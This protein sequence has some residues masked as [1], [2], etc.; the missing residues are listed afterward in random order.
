[1]RLSTLKLSLNFE[2]LVSNSGYAPQQFG[3][4]KGNAWILVNFIGK[5]DCLFNSDL[6]VSLVMEIYFQRQPFKGLLIKGCSGNIQQ[7][8]RRTPMP[9]NDFNKVTLQLYWNH[10][11]GWEFSCKFVAYSQNNFFL[12]YPWRAASVFYCQHVAC[13]KILKHLNFS[14]RTIEEGMNANNKP[15]I[16]HYLRAGLANILLF[17]HVLV[18]F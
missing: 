8:Y 2:V 6:R 17:F 9:K 11:S 13:Y 18:F 16:T 15:V 5:Q 14:L 12:E 3:W 1:M 10:T 7:I 4:L